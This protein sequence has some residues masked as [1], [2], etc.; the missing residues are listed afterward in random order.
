ML[1]KVEG[2][3][4]RLLQAHKAIFSALKAKAPEDAS[5]WMEK[6][7]RDFRR[8][9]EATGFDLQAAINPEASRQSAAS[10]SEEN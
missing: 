8:G 1:S 9:Y 4:S 3:G 10:E 7:I 6:H 2:S 5:Q